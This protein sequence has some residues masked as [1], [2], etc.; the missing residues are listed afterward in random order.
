MHARQRPPTESDQTLGTV[1]VSSQ[2]PVVVWQTR[3]CGDHTASRV[4]ERDDDFGASSAEL[5]QVPACVV[6]QCLSDDLALRGMGL[7]SAAGVPRAS[8]IG[9]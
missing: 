5:F 6:S 7:R 8:A 2:N 1:G 4:S 3:E 9:V